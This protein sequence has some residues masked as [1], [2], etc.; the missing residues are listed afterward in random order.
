MS[1]NRI[2]DV[3]LRLLTAVFASKPLGMSQESLGRSS[4]E[5]EGSLASH[6]GP[7]D[8]LSILATSMPAFITTLG[9]SERV[10]AAVASI[11]TNVVA[12]LFRSRAFPN[13]VNRNI[14]SLLEQTAKIPAAV[15]IW[16]KDVA[17]AFNDGRFFGSHVDQVKGGWMDIFRQW[18]LVD[19]DKLPELMSR[20]PPPSTAGI[21]FGVGAGAARLDADR[22]AQLNLRRMGLLIVSASED[23]FAGSLSGLLQKLEDLITATNTS[24]PSSATR[25]EIFMVLR[26]LILKTTPGAIAPFWPLISA[27]LQEAI[28]SISIQ[29]QQQRHHH[30]HHQD[31]YNPY[32]LLQACKLLDLLLVLA[33][34]EF[35][36]L[37]WLF[38][39][40]SVDALYPPSN[41]QRWGSI[42]L[43]DEISRNLSSPFPIE[44]KTSDDDSSGTKR[45]PW[46]ISKRIETIPKEE[47]IDRI[48]GPFLG[49]LSIRTFE[50]TYNMGIPDWDCCLDNLLVDLFDESTMVS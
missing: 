33:P 45:R 13:N 35:Q 18:T 25:A 28:S 14:L 17:D 15:K 34:D 6:V 4:V 26:A 32:S 1:T 24:S 37:E 27:E 19:K 9:D 40:D 11:S 7:D 5:Y 46:L 22:K 44:E 47:I 31:V 38:V 49:R 20:V 21:M 8:M 43:A 41:N 42:A 48:L 16:K 30:H 2:K 23:Y 39:T 12:P 36:L 10:N 29:Q 3:L 50:S